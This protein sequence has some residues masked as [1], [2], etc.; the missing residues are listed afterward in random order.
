MSLHKNEVIDPTFKGN[1]TGGISGGT[2]QTIQIQSVGYEPNSFFV[3]KQVYDDK[4]G[5]P[6][7]GLYADLNRDGVINENDQ[8]HYK[9]PFAPYTMGLTN[10]FSYKSW[11]L[12]MVFRANIGNYLYNN[13]QSNLGVTRNIVNVNGY[14]QNA[15]VAA[16]ETNFFNNQFQSDYYIENAS[17]LKMDNLGLSYNIGKI[18]QNKANLTIG[19]NC[20]NVFVVTKYSGLDPE[21]FYG[22]DNNIYPRPRTYSFSLNLSF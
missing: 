13:V 12:N 22:I 3:Y 9:S 21:L 10:N 5:K 11:S 1:P 14:L 15:P 4:T 16:L 17:F 6:I 20:Q 19:A 18:F 8:Y 2:G 7:E